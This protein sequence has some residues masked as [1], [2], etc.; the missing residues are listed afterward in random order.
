MIPLHNAAGA[1]LWLSLSLLWQIYIRYTEYFCQDVGL[2]QNDLQCVQFDGS[3]KEDLP[4][5]GLKKQ[6]KKT[7]Q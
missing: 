3:E 7:T 1:T 6:N 2:S 4:G 5:F